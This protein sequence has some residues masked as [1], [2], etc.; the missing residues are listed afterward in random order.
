MRCMTFIMMCAILLATM[1]RADW[2]A[3]PETQQYAMTRPTKVG[4]TFSPNDDQLFASGWRRVASE[5]LAP[6]IPDG[7][8]RTL[9]TWVQHPTLISNAVEQVVDQPIPPANFPYGA[10]MLQRLTV[11][12][13]VLIESPARAVVLTDTNG[14]LW[15]LYPNGLGDGVWAQASGSPEHSLD[16]RLAE[17]DRLLSSN[18]TLRAGLAVLRDVVATNINDCQLIDPSVWTGAQRTQAQALRRELIDVNQSLREVVRILRVMR[19]E[20]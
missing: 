7:Y 17:R 16:V 1:A 4:S 8:E 13:D 11:S 15:A 19:R 3:I 12:E 10:D 6:A 5:D 20:E 2:W 9:R 14:V 18:A